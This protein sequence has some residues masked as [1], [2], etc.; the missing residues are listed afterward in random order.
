[1]RAVIAVPFFDTPEND[2]AG[3]TRRTFATLRGQ[4]ERPHL[5]IGVDNGSTDKS[6]L[7]DVA[8]L[9]DSMVIL[10]EPHSIAYG[11]NTAW[12]LYED[13]LLRGES[14][15]VKHDS[16]LNIKQNDWLSR[17][18]DLANEI[19]GLIGPRHAR[20]DYS[21]WGELRKDNGHWWESNFV[22]GGVTMRTPEC[23]RAIGYT[24]QPYGRWGWQD[25]FDCRRIRENTD[26]KIAIFKDLVFESHVGHSALPRDEKKAIQDRGRQ[27]LVKR[28]REIA[29]GE[30]PL[31]QDFET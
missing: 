28:L 8:E 4:V 9:A 18:M 25:N 27:N 16:D 29:S 6:A 31:Y 5:I 22:H 24:W 19:S 17:M 21:T 3:S 20:I 10:G 12:K 23:F 14:V 11:V 13:E 7:R 2:R 1:M 26:L 30:H 15:A